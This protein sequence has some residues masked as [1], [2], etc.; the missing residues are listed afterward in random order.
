MLDQYELTV[1]IT[2]KSFVKDIL[3]KLVSLGFNKVH[4]GKTP[5]ADADEFYLELIVYGD[6]VFIAI[7]NAINNLMDIKSITIKSILANNLTN[8]RISLVQYTRQFKQNSL[9]SR[10]DT[11]SFTTLYT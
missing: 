11:S 3:G 4:I 8:K 2:T 1:Y 6:T 9:R 5:K 7:E 10:Y